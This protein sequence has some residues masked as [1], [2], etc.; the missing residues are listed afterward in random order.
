MA[1]MTGWVEREG[2]VKDVD[3]DVVGG[4]VSKGYEGVGNG[5]NGDLEEKTPT[6]STSEE[7]F[8]Y[9]AKGEA[10]VYGL[11]VEK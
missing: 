6:T 3:G 9:M 5:G 1:G 11:S 8:D 10:S 7:S 4:K 2:D